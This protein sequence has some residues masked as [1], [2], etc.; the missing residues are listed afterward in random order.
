MVIIQTIRTA[1]SQMKDGQRALMERALGFTSVSSTLLHVGMLSIDHGDEE[2]RGAAYDLLGAICTYLGYDKNPIVA[3]EGRFG[4]PYFRSCIDIISIVAGFIPED[5]STFVI[6]LS[7][8]LAHFASHLTLDFITEVCSRMDKATAA[9]RINCLQYLSPWI[10][11]LAKYCDPANP[12]YEHSGARL[13]DAIRLLVDLT[14][15][16]YGVSLAPDRRIQIYSRVLLDY[17]YR[18]KVRLV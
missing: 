12:L 9:Q 7:S 17:L 2:L 14:T 11:N 18:S 16:D 1:K 15:S 6:R 10:P 5:P 13:R 8:R 3:P 4:A